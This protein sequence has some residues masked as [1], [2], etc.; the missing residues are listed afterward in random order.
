MACHGAS[1][2][3]TAEHADGVHTE[4][5]N[6]DALQ[7]SLMVPWIAEVDQTVLFKDHVSFKTPEDQV[8]SSRCILHT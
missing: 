5:K 4:S 1:V 3:H 2:E 8:S 6:P 7:V